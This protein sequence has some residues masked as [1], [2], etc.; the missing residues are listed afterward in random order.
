MRDLELDKLAQSFIVPGVRAIA[1]LG[2]RATGTHGR[3][4]D[5]DFWRLTENE[6]VGAVRSHF[7]GDVLVNVSDATLTAAET[8]F[9]DPVIATDAIAGVRNARIIHDPHGEFAALQRRAVNFVWND[10]LKIRAIEYT[11]KQMVGWIEEAFKG[12]SGLEYNDAGRMLSARHGL[13]WGLTTVMRVFHGVLAGGDND[14]VKWPARQFGAGDEWTRLQSRA[15]GVSSNNDVTT[16]REQVIAGL[17]LYLLTAKVVSPSL[18][19]EHRDKVAVAV[20]IIDAAMNEMP[21]K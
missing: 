21:K 3:F 7:Y 19:P 5:I 15:F 14:V 10:D 20:R 2:S 6:T 4:S 17:K 1:L 18:L 16:L 12:L 13:S 11:G 9:S 8:W